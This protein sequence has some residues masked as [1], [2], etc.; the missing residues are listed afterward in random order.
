M[1]G[2]YLPSL[3]Q[4]IAAY[5]GEP[6]VAISRWCGLGALRWEDRRRLDMILPADVARSIGIAIGCSTNE[7]MDGMM[8]S[9]VNDALAPGVDGLPAHA[10]NWT[11]GSGT[12]YCPQ[13]LAARPAVFLAHWRLWWSFLCETHLVPLHDTCP[14]CGHGIPDPALM[15]AHPVDPSSCRARLN[16]GSRCGHDLRATWHEA[17]FDNSAP[18]VRAQVAISAAWKRD[19]ETLDVFIPDVQHLFPTLRGVGI[20]LLA[21]NDIPLIAELAELDPPQLQ[22]LFDET[23]R[24]GTAPPK[25][26]LAMG[27]LMAASFTLMFAREETVRA[28]IR[29]LTFARPSERGQTERSPGS[30]ATLLGY[31]PGVGPRFRGRILRAIDQ[32]LPAMQRL[33]TGS[34][35]RAEFDEPAVAAYIGFLTAQDSLRNPEWTADHIPPLLWT[36]WAVP[37]SVA[38]GADSETL[39]RSLALGLTAA[40]AGTHRDAPDPEVI[41][42]IGR[43]L[44]PAMLGAPAQTTAILRQLGELARYLAAST[45]L[46]NYSTR[47]RHLPWW[48]LLDQTHWDMICASVGTFTGSRQRLLNARRYLYLRATAQPT[49]AL[50][51]PWA[52][53]ANGRDAAEYTDF[54]I[55]MTAQLQLALDA[56]LEAWLGVTIDAVNAYD[57]GK[58]TCPT[59]VWEPPRWAGPEVVHLGPELDDIDVPALHE[60]VGSGVTTVRALAAVVQRTPQHV[61][62]ALRKHPVPSDQPVLP[63]D[64]SLHLREVPWWPYLPIMRT[65]QRAEC[66]FGRDVT[67]LVPYGWHGARVRSGVRGNQFVDWH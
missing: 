49:S 46:I 13:C 19:R 12:R 29:R 25:N 7:L 18:V 21:A 61:R 55:R 53:T 6:P 40:L 31:W 35:V 47:R 1:P 52:V 66:G 3:L 22:G 28:V 50:P 63:I 14:A 15:E 48:Q 58:G 60:L 34:A 26:A 10:K 9:F 54:Q 4:R 20:A 43:R 5:V 11:R 16:D 65:P 67:L 37:L 57:R 2:E 38:G 24:V 27:A 17:P 51:V 36:N 42:G 41:A 39:Q 30:A 59:A 44:R 23:A 45:P 32:D 56:Y 8:R 64:W 33:V 62:W